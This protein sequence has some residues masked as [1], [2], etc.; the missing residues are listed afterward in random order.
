MRITLLIREPG[1]LLHDHVTTL[2]DYS[3]SG[4]HFKLHD[5]ETGA[6]GAGLE[7]LGHLDD[8]RLISNFPTAWEVVGL[9]ANGCHWMESLSVVTQFYSAITQLC[10]SLG[11]PLHVIFRALAG[12]VV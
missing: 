9:V 7:I 2:S 11:S 3:E 12:Q 10:C 1:H 4:V 8:N 5:D 6:V